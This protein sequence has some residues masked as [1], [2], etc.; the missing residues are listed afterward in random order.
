VHYITFGP[1]CRIKRF[2]KG[3]EGGRRKDVNLVANR[4]G[5]VSRFWTEVE[6]ERESATDFTERDTM[7]MCPFPVTVY[8]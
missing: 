3:E 6:G 4:K 5:S 8:K 7:R 2:V 1:V